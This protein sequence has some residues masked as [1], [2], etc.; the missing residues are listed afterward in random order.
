MTTT[1]QLTQVFNDNFV[2]Y[3][4]SHAAHANIVGRNFASD[5]QLL[6]GI[7]ESLQ[8][9][10]DTIGELLRSLYDYMPCGIEEVLQNSITY[11]SSLLECY[12]ASKM[13]VILT[14]WPEF[15]HIVNYSDFSQKTLLDL[16]KM[17]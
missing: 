8:E 11:C 5:H 12:N 13:V 16:R 6:G 17:L 15:K 7:Y 9:Q 4:R 3:Y 14:E 2:A 1:E 10:I